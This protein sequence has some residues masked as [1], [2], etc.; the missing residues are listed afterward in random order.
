MYGERSEDRTRWWETFPI[1]RARYMYVLSLS[2]ERTASRR[3]FTSNLTRLSA[4]AADAMSRQYDIY[5]GVLPRS[6]LSAAAKAVAARDAV[7]ADIDVGKSGR[8]ATIQHALETVHRFALAPTTLSVSG[9]GL[10]VRTQLDRDL[11]HEMWTGYQISYNAVMGGDMAAIDVARV[12]RVPDTLNFKTAPPRPVKLLEVNAATTV[13]ALS[14]ALE[15]AGHQPQPA[16]E[17]QAIPGRIRTPHSGRP[18]DLA[19]DVPIC[20]VLRFLG[21]SSFIEE[22]GRL[23]CNCPLCPGPDE[24]ELVV[25]GR[26]NVATCFGDCRRSYTAV[27]LV[28]AVRGVTPREAVGQLAEEF[29]FLGFPEGRS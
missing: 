21:V 24:R 27:D 13:E 22:A 6:G 3:L 17:V 29:G 25:G 11:P 8:H 28:M 7:F 23:H 12:H 18:F 4:F 5:Y 9:S 2:R 14:A 10:H 16:S 26:A 19:N 1:G 20:D 15:D